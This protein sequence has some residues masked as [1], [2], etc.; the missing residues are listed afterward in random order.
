[1]LDK[2]TRT[3]P[4]AIVSQI[5]HVRVGGRP[6]MLS[7]PDDDDDVYYRLAW[8]LKLLPDLNLD[9]LTVLGDTIGTVAY[10]LWTV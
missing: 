6:L 2:L 4:A 8:A 1:M 10:I 5:W 7:P 9:K 3:D